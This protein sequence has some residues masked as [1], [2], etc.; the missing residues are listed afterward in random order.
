MMA[1]IPDRR[2]CRTMSLFRLITTAFLLLVASTTV[3]RAEEVPLDKIV[4]VVNSDV[5]LQSELDDAM[6][7]AKLQIQQRNITPPPEDVLRSQVLDRLI[8][9]RLQLLKAEEDGIRV[10]DRELNQVINDIANR[11]GLTVTQ[12]MDQLKAEGL[13]PADV[14]DQLR[15]EVTINHVRQHE[16]DSRVTITDQDVDLYLA[17]QQSSSSAE[18]HLSHILIEVSDGASPKD[19]A[20]AKAKAEDILKKIRD[21]ADFA[22]MAISFSNGQQALKGGDLD[23]MSAGDLPVAFAKAA[24][25]L[26]EGEVSDVLETAS[27]FHIIK[28]DG[29]RSNEPRKTVEESHARH[30]LIQPNAIR[31]DEQAHDLAEQLYERIQKGEDFAK[32]AKEYSDD[33]GSKNAGGDLGWQAPG[34]FVKDF[35][36][37]MDQLKP[38]EISPPFHTQFGWHIVQLLERRTRDVTDETRRLQARQAIFQRKEAEDYD[39]WLRRLRDES[40]VEYR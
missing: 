25:H 7:A 5:I 22:Q 40:Y 4:A 34:V 12:F 13:D 3:L 28:L 1:R 26:K 39:V 30:I 6:D 2:D 23:W 20:A 16:V 29:V 31:T 11:N 38:N 27:G 24:A 14:R 15:D 37:R 35:Q 32:L 9:T 21:G 17:Q 36:L 33:P 19:R 18:Y 8:L 10:D